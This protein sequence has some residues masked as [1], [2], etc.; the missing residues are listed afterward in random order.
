MHKMKI[1][2]RTPSPTILTSTSNATVMTITRRG[3]SAAKFLWT[4]KFDANFYRRA[5]LEKFC[6][7]RTVEI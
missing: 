2:L 3:I 5:R 6:A 7:R 1:T 4:L